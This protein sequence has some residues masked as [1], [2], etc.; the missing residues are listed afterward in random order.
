ML[1]GRLNLLHL[2]IIFSGDPFIINLISFV[3]K[4]CT[5]AAESKLSLYIYFLKILVL[6]WLESIFEKSLLIKESFKLYK[7]E[8]IVLLY[9]LSVLFLFL[10]FLNN[11][12]IL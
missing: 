2:F 12:D 8:I 4:L 5:I 1:L 6:W 3:N 9:E 11:S 10:S 7:C